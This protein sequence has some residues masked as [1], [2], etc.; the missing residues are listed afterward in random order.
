MSDKQLGFC[1]LCGSANERGTI[2]S[3]HP[4]TGKPLYRI[5][6]SRFECQN[7]AHEHKFKWFLD[8]TCSICG[9]FLRIK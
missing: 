6:C 2:Q 5:R 3:Y 9:K 8:P 7:G 4:E 1:T